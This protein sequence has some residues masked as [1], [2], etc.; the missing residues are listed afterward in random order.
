VQTQLARIRH[1]FTETRPQRLNALLMEG[2]TIHDL[3]GNVMKNR[4]VLFR[5]GGVFYCE[6]TTTGKQSSLRTKD[7]AEANTL[8]HAKNESFRQPVI[9]LQIART[10]LTACD[11][12]LS[13]R[14][15]QHVMEQII[16]TK[17]GPTR[18]RWEFASRDKAFDLIR[19]RKLVET[20]A[21]QFLAVLK[22]GTVSTNVYLRRAH[23]Y[24]L[25]LNWLPW[26]VL[27]RNH[28]PQVEYKDKR[29]ITLEEHEKII[30]RERNP[31]T[32]AFFQLLWHLGGSQSDVA[33][34]TAE[35]IDWRNRTVAYQRNKTGVAA[36]ISFGDE[37]ANI[38][39]T[40]PES[41]LLFPALARIHERHR[42]KLFIKRLATVGI[43]GV[44][45]HSYR[46]AW[47]ERAKQ[48][49]YP[50]RFAMHALGHNSKA[51]HRA[52]AKNAQI[53]LPP[54]EEYEKRMKANGE[55]SLATSFAN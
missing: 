5:R 46:Y 7:E 16:S 52:Y 33:N 31:A 3:K 54:L 30:Q 10:Y 39:K 14:T 23:N 21:E 47:A 44:S 42:A 9:N 34:L 20:T 8:L 15:W 4:F 18:E 40:L 55:I 29:A 19:H 50:E 53:T 2:F 49:G 41:G 24:A 32:R 51:V 28:W 25:G 27:P 1:N 17:Q 36:T 48:A 43:S 13:A 22:S 11:P 26:P 6:D 12:A 37:V 45:L 38:L 35:N